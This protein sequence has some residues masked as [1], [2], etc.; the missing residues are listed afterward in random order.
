MYICTYTHTDITF[1][2]NT[3]E[4]HAYT[5][6][7]M[8]GILH[9]TVHSRTYI[10]TLYQGTQVTYVGQK[11]KHNK[12]THM[13]AHLSRLSNLHFI[14]VISPRS[15]VSLDVTRLPPT[16]SLPLALY[17]YFILFENSQTFVL[18]SDFFLTNETE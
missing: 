12:R 8:P 3:Y 4:A 2:Q 18:F 11:Y 13:L 9:K 10:H 5:Y 15:F 6:V 16:L 14:L 1:V 7:C 17:L